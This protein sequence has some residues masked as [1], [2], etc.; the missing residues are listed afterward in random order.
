MNRLRN[1]DKYTAFRDTYQVFSFDSCNFQLSDNFIR[2]KFFFSIDEKIHFQPETTFTIPEFLKHWKTEAIETLVFHVGMVE[3]ISYWKSVC[4]KKVVIRP[5]S[6]SPEQLNWWKK[7]WFNGLGEFFWLNSI[8]TT[9]D[10]FMEL[11][12]A[13]DKAPPSVDFPEVRQGVIVPVGG[14]KDSVVSLEFFQ[15]MGKEVFPMIVNPREAQYQTLQ[16]AGISQSGAF[17]A[18][19]EIH[20]VLLEMNAQGCL[21]GHTPF[22]SLLAFQSLLFSYISGISLIALSNESSAN[23]STV[24]GTNVNH[25]YSKSFEFEHDFR[26][27]IHQYLSPEFNYFSVLRPLSELQIA[28]AFSRFEKHVDV[29]RSCNAGSKENVW[30]GKCPKCLFTA[31]ILLPFT[32][33]EKLIRVFGKDM[34]D[35]GSLI[36]VLKQLTGIDPVKPFE[37]VGTPEEINAALSYAVDGSF[38]GKTLPALLDFFRKSPK[39]RPVSSEELNDILTE[40]FDIQHFLTATMYE[41]LLGFIRADSI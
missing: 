8:H 37:C 9:Q 34:F 32:G 4:P 7:L 25:Q 29:F 23:E 28:F 10:D 5:F 11:F 20:P 35:D 27:Y 38:G 36:P 15:Q 22:S 6:L 31:I 3:L 33:P 30:C 39:Y 40:Q 21:N 1:F 24:P 14:G 13:S 12:C 19:R 16:A 18:Q 41:Q 2:A 17:I 26:S